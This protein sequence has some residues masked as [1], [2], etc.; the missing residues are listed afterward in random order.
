M[1]E[2]PGLEHDGTNVKK[3]IPVKTEEIVKQRVSSLN[4]PYIK[5]ESAEEQTDKRMQDGK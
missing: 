1:K 5:Q 4:K 2:E 3:K